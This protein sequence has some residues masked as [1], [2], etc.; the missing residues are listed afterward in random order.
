[1]KF[2]YGKK[3]CH[4]C[5]LN[6]NCDLKNSKTNLIEEP[7]RV[8]KPFSERYMDRLV[9]KGVQG[10]PDPPVI[11]SYCRDFTLDGDKTQ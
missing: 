11:V 3:Q 4:C 5:G 2:L 8:P 6:E 10:I 1:M 7:K 9:T